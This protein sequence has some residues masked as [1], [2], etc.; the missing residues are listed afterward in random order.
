[1]ERRI[2][3]KKNNKMVS[4][5][6]VL[7]KIKSK[8]RE[9]ENNVRV[10]ET[11]IRGHENQLTDLTE[12]RDIYYSELAHIYLPELDAD[13]VANTLSGMK[14]EITSIFR[15]KQ[16]KRDQLENLM[17]EHEEERD[18]LDKKLGA[19]TEKL[20]AKAQERDRLQKE[21]ANELEK[22]NEYQNL[23]KKAQEANKRL[24]ANKNRVTE[25]Q[26]EAEQKLPDFQN[27]RLF[28]YLINSGYN[29]NIHN[30]NRN[31]QR[32]DS[33][34]AKL[35][36][37][38]DNKKC[39]DFL[40]SMPQLIDNEVRKRQKELDNVVNQ[41]VSIEGGYS[42]NLGLT[43][44]IEQGTVLAR[45]RDKLMEEIEKIEKEYGE[46]S[47]QRTQL[48][49]TK[50]EYHQEAIKKLKSYMKGSTIRDLKQK[51]R[52]TLDPRD[53][54]LVIKIGEIDDKIKSQKYEVKMKEGERDKLNNKLLEFQDTKR[55]FTRNDYES[56]GSEFSRDLD[57]DKLLTGFLLGT[58]TESDL[59][60]QIKRAQS[61]K[62][63]ETYSFSSS[64]DSSQSSR[65]N[66]SSNND[67]GGGGFISSG[68]FGGGGFSTTGGF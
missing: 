63:R 52:E 38:D 36:H 45:R 31:I 59:F 27:S 11:E 23:H 64:Y 46:Y 51:A 20:D 60:S 28:M 53:D 67:F 12:K 26:N 34:V 47:K 3:W 62:P 9:V 16:R 19:V 18:L 61:F 22:N 48:E 33:W 55:K 6:T 56:S 66:P 14:K 35:V 5:N 17:H 7:G 39:Y 32:L 29:T 68:G 41:L 49:N 2:D 42:D 8:I 44:C 57:M 58:Y 30:Y 54:H 4:G 13:S 15:G 50:G 25:V 1:M 10:F 40:R 21:L 37:F 65:S 43:E 24:E